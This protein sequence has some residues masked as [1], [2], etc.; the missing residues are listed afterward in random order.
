[1]ETSYLQRHPF[2]KDVLGILVF[3]L[4]VLIGTLLINTYIFR[5]FNVSGPSMETTLYTGDRLIVNRLPVT[6]SQLQNKSYIPERGEIIVFKNPLYSVSTGDEFIVKRV[7]AFPGE[8][9]VVKDGVITIYNQERPD[10]FLPDAAQA[11]DT[12]SQPGTPTS[13]DVDTVVPDESLF[14]AGDH[15]T[16]DYSFDS[17]SGLG[18]VPYYDVVGPVGVRIWPFDKIRLF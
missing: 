5:T 2:L 18:T 4:C 15:R 1:M 12:G 11:G 6:W 9:V 3:I 10:G 8:R 16:G 14:V 13:G 17:R 7:I